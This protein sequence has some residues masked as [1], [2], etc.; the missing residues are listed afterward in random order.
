MSEVHAQAL[1]PQWGSCTYYILLSIMVSILK[2]V[3][4]IGSPR[5]ILPLAR[6]HFPVGARDFD[7]GEQ[8]C[9]VVRFHDVA[10]EG[11]LEPDGA[12]VRSLMT[13]VAHARIYSSVG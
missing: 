11:V 12:V 6:H 3:V 13:N 5:L 9:L 2:E 8:A 10:A 7:T 1:G 4:F